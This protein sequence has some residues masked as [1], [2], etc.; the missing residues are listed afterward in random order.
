MKTTNYAWINKGIL[1]PGSVSMHCDIKIKIDISM[2][3]NWFYNPFGIAYPNKNFTC[4]E[5]FSIGLTQLNYL[6]LEEFDLD[7][8]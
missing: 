4:F 3:D 7:I 6:D 5:T 8:F 2:E 1:R